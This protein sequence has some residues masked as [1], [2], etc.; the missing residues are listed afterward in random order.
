MTEDCERVLEGTSTMNTKKK[1]KQTRRSASMR[2]EVFVAMRDA[3]A[4]QG[5]SVSGVLEKLALGWLAEHGIELQERNEAIARLERESQ[6]RR[7]NARVSGRFYSG[8]MT[9]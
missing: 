5:C 4:A 8:N 1:H 7:D 9:F 2:G 3:C 6:E